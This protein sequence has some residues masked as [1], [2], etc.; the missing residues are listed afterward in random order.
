[1]IKIFSIA[2]K[3]QTPAEADNWFFDLQGGN[4]QNQ[5][6]ILQLTINGKNIDSPSGKKL[7][8]AQSEL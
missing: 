6:M 4:E 3:I 1:M 5:P 2:V 7:Q 8:V